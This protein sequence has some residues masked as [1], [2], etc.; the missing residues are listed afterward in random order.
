MARGSNSNFGK[1]LK[2]LREE[3]RLSQ[4]AVSERSGISVQTISR[5]ER[6][7]RV[8]D[9]NAA[10]ALCG[11]LGVNPEEFMPEAERR[12]VDHRRA[13]NELLSV[14]EHLSAADIRKLIAEARIMGGRRKR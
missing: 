8:P 7:L 2:R 9:W 12:S 5:W 1:R 4:E 3:R 11:A 13:Q 14:T 6:D 10:L